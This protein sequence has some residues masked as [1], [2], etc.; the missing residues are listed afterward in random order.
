MLGNF[1]AFVTSVGFK[2]FGYRFKLNYFFVLFFK[3]AT[4]CKI[5]PF[6]VIA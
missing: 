2:T 1:L 5:R 4:F 6:E 3:Y